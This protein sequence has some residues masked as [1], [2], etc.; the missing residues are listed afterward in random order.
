MSPL[1]LAGKGTVVTHTTE[2]VTADGVEAPVHVA[3]VKLAEGER[4]K[5]PTRVLARGANPF[6]SGETVTLE[7]RGEVLWAEKA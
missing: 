2:E 3:V 4:G 7:A 6:T 1:R 5:A